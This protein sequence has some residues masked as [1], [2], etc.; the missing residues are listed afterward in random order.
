MPLDSQIPTAGECECGGRHVLDPTTID[1][2]LVTFRCSADDCDWE[3]AMAQE[4]L[5][6][7]AAQSET[8]DLDEIRA[9]PEEV[10]VA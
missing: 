3:T 1:E 8:V 4:R 9:N 2:P 7:A 10:P 5:Q 6:D